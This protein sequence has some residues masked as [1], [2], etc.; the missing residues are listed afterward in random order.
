MD[1][2][3]FGFVVVALAIGALIGWLVGSRAAAGAKQTVD[4]LR[5]QLDEV[6]KERDS[7]RAAVAEL[8]GAE[9]RAGGAGESFEQ[10][11]AALKDAKESLS[12]QFHEI[13]NKLLGDAR[14]TFLDQAGEKFT[15]AVL[16]GRDLAQDLSGEAPDDREGAGRPLCRPS[17]GGR[18]G[19]DGAG[20][21]ARRDTPPRQCAARFAQGA[22][23]LGRAEPQERART[24]G[25]DRA[26]R[27]P[28]R[29]F[30]GYRRRSPAPRRHRQPARWPQA[31]DRRQMLAQF[32]FG[33]LRRGR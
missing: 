12:A 11:I 20:A 4:N 32:L 21:G 18:A 16:A 30:G 23:P 7:N 2:A 3:V 5:L 6:V 14:K 1:A 24:G 27:F 29:S 10:Q 17:R 26:C 8:G 19:A 9:G 31:G 22:R 15:Q 25:P 33:R 13:A 28:D